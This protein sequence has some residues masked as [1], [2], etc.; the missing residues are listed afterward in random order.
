[1]S[2]FSA[3]KDFTHGTR[4]TIGVLVA[5]LGTPQAPQPRELRIY[6]KEFLSDPRVVEVPRL[7]WWMI[8][9][10]VILN[11]RPKRSAKAYAKVWTEQGSPLM[12]HSKAQ[13]SAL[14]AQLEQNIQSPV[15]LELAMRYGEPSVKH[16]LERLREAGVTRLIVLPLYPQYSASTTASVFDA[17]F[18][19]FKTWRVVPELRTVSGY[20]T[21]PNFIAALA[22]SIERYWAEHGRG[23]KLLL[24]FH[25]IP[26]RYFDNGD[27]YHCLC[28]ATAF[29]VAG[30]LGLGPDAWQLT[31]QSRF[32]REPWLK[33]YTDHTL[34]SLGGQGVGR[35]DVV[36]PGF[37]SDC[38]ETL[39]EI[40]M[41]NREIFLGAGGKDFHYIPC[42]NDDESHISALAS[43]VASRIQDW[44]T[45]V[46]S[47]SASELE[48]VR[49]RASDM[50]A[51]A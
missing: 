29:A 1:M 10:L 18:D 51:R 14:A 30:K 23:D 50:G 46:A 35:V 2:G 4:E 42:L 38:I 3:Q 15:H 31:F 16:A 45:E 37:A 21:D 19:T 25:G 5:N 40:D 43:L 6:L 36:C 41:E 17:V 8:L 7:L 12:V 28:H 9:N 24:S 44:D 11:I 47:R 26:Q 22:S 39:E 20:H 48:G 27:P 33:P 34:E 49:H 13:A 32:G